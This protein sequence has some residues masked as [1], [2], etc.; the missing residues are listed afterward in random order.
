MGSGKRDRIAKELLNIIDSYDSD[1]KLNDTNDGLICNFCPTNL[2]TINEFESINSFKMYISDHTQSVEHKMSYDSYINERLKIAEEADSSKFSLAMKYLKN[3]V[4]IAS[5]KLKSVNCTICN[6]NINDSLTEIAKH[7][8]SNQHRELQLKSSKHNR[9]VIELVEKSECLTILNDTI[10]CF[11]CNSSIYSDISNL[12]RHLMTE[13]HKSSMMR[14][15]KHSAEMIYNKDFNLFLVTLFVSNNIPL[16]KITGMSK[17]LEALSKGQ[18]ILDESSYRTYYLP[19]VYSLFRDLVKKQVSNK[20]IFISIDETTEYQKSRKVVVV[21]IGTLIPDEPQEQKVFMWDL[22]WIPPNTKWDNEFVLKIF[23]QTL[24][25]IYDNKVDENKHKVRLLVTDGGSQL[26]KAGKRLVEEFGFGDHMFTL[27]CLVHGIH[28]VCEVIQGQYKLATKF[29]HAVPNILVHSQEKQKFFL[30]CIQGKK[31]PPAPIATRWGTVL[32]A[33]LYHH[34]HFEREIL[35]LSHEIFK[36]QRGGSVYLTQAL[37]LGKDPNLKNELDEV[38][39][40]YRKWPYRIKGMESNHLDIRQ[41]FRAVDNF[42]NDLKAC[43]PCP[44]AQNAWDKFKSVFYNKNEGYVQLREAIESNDPKFKVYR[45][46]PGGSYSCE[47]AFS[48]LNDILTSKRLLNVDSAKMWMMIY[49]NAASLGYRTVRE[50]ER[51]VEY[52][53]E[54]EGQQSGYLDESANFF[55]LD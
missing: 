40:R 15:D 20:D 51:A 17:G 13:K 39:N 48:S 41:Q 24:N 49:I 11:V 25:E 7:I 5:D 29:A 9:Q 33:I 27:K 42:E 46:A 36:S 43:F 6:L 10:T 18:K 22:H 21:M 50:R 52:D 53:W 14:Y 44:K 16:F 45:F 19:R 32:S 55:K 26:I 30:E 31:L 54:N 28:N 23:F 8:C 12:N 1:F 3:G 35:T 34:D 37:D 47:R 2:S 38:N 4:I